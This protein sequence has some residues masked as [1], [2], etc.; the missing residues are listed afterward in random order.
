[1]QRTI[2][3]L[4]IILALVGAP[5]IARAGVGGALGG[6]FVPPTKMGGGAANAGDITDVIAGVGLTGGAATG[7]ATLTVDTTYVQRR[8]SGTCLSSQK[9]LSIN[10]DGS[11]NCAADNDTTYTAGSGI[12]SLG[13]VIAIDPTYT[14]RRIGASCAVGSSIRIVNQ[15]GT[16]GCQV[17]ADT[18]YTAGTGLN[19]TGTVFS[20]LSGCATNQIPKWT[21]TIWA[22]AVDVDTNSGGTITGV[23]AQAPISGG[24]TTGAI[25]VGLTACATNEI[26][27]W[28][29]TAWACATDATGS[30][31]TSIATTFPVAGGPITTTGTLSLS[32][33]T[34]S[35]ILKMNAGATAYACA[36]DIDTNSGGTVTSIVASTGLSGGTITGTGT[37]ALANTTVAP[38][39]YTNTSLTVDAQGRITTASS[40]AAGVTG[41]GTANMLSKFGAATSLADSPVFSNTATMLEVASGTILDWSSTAVA[42]GVIDVGLGR[43]FAGTLEV[44]NGVLG[45]YRDMLFRALYLTG[46][47]LMAST[48]LA[49]WS[50]TASPTGTVDAAIGRNGVGILEVNNGTA[51]TFASLK[52]LNG[53][54]SGAV[55]VGTTLDVTGNATIAATGLLLAKG[56]RTVQGIDSDAGALPAVTGATIVSVSGRNSFTVNATAASVVATFATAYTA[57]PTCVVSTQGATKTFTYT[58]ALASISIGTATATQDYDISCTGHQ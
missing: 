42:S 46:N 50:S 33:C 11:A 19:L 29:G 36:A 12:T 28:N 10:A 4:G 2:I 3:R 23:T 37:I 43:N 40:G 7:A 20:L 6:G 26:Y 53:T 13:N 55:A 16:V 49:G 54:F 48:G 47:H 21:G 52:A 57:M 34:A 58:K 30:G 51:G 41:T 38:A 14:Q 5:V 56:P 24:G 22:C 44:N 17:D 32:L 35:Q 27:K 31:V 39:A 9:L 45:T 1:M 25:N 8:V 15:D 18:T